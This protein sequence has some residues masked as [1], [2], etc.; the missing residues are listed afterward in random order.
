MAR[1]KS[2]IY[3][4]YNTKDAHELRGNPRASRK[5]QEQKELGLI[6][7]LRDVSLIFSGGLHFN[8][9]FRI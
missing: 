4:M 9:S 6:S 2:K 3:N 8:P 7:L 1:Y 5:S